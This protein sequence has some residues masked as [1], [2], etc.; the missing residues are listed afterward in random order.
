M[1][2]TPIPLWA[3]GPAP[4][5]PGRRLRAGRRGVPP[6]VLSLL[7]EPQLALPAFTESLR[8]LV[9]LSESGPIGAALRDERAVGWLLDAWRGAPR[10]A[11][12][13]PRSACTTR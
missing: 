9:E 4:K 12:P 13:A 5:R 2:L 3:S 11:R 10:V 8:A 1:T 7:A 6:D